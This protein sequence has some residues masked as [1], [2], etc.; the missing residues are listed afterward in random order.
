MDTRRATPNRENLPGEPFRD[1][2]G[3]LW[4]DF[5][6]SDADSEQVTSRWHVRWLATTGSTNADVALAADNGAPDRLVLVADHQTS[7]RGRLDRR[8][9]APPGVNLLVTMLFRDVPADAHVLTHAVALAAADACE[10]LGRRAGCAIDVRLKW[11]NDVIARERKLAGILASAS[12]RRRVTGGTDVPEYVL[13]GLGLNVLWAPD[14]AVSLG[15][16]I[17]EVHRDDVLFEILVILD[18][19]L[20]ID[21]GTLDDLY[22]SRVAT[23]GQRVRVDLPSGESL[24]GRAMAVGD[25]GR[26]E[27]LDEC[28]ITH[29]LDV[30]DIVHLR[31]D[32]E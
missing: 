7:G 10:E 28:A 32:D 8:W 27:V 5:A 9:E 22:R 24:R 1:R 23:I 6:I 18:R 25:D 17:G 21:R 31:P 30:A 12:A 3:R 2:N 4:G 13:V 20:R 29:R 26:L 16:M 15:D 11:P 19:L 14:D